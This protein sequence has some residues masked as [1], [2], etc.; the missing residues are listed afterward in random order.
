MLSKGQVQHSSRDDSTGMGAASCLI[1]F[2][3]GG[4]KW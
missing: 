4:G 2:K 1:R 3:V